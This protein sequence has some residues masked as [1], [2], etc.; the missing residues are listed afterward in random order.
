MYICNIFTKNS[1]FDEIFFGESKLFILT[2][3]GH[4]TEWNVV[5]WIHWIHSIFEVNVQFVL[6]PFW[7]QCTTSLIE[8]PLF[9]EL[10]LINLPDWPSSDIASR[11]TWPKF[12]PI[13]AKNE[14]APS[15][16]SIAQFFTDSERLIG[17]SRRKTPFEGSRGLKNWAIWRKLKI[18]GVLM[19]LPLIFDI[20]HH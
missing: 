1:W 8:C 13:W 9:G 17:V 6:L 7:S 16:W 18:Q 3:F 5:K 15:F 10:C 12:G 2:H 20:I 11:V 19:V 4:I 14:V